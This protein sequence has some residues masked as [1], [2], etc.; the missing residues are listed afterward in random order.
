MSDE[1]VIRVRYYDGQYLRI[2][3][4]TDEQNYHIRMRRRHNIGG[5][6]WGVVR[7]LG[8]GLTDPGTDPKGGQGPFLDP[9]MAID[10]FG[11]EL[12]VVQ[13][14]PLDINQFDLWNVDVLDVWLNYSQS[15]SNPTAPGYGDCRSPSALPGLFNR[16]VEDPVLSYEPAGTNPDRRR[17]RVIAPGDNPFGP[18]RTPPDSPQVLWPVF[19][20]RFWRT[21]KPLLTSNQ[22]LY[23]VDIS[24][25]PY[26]GLVGESVVAPSGLA[27][28]QLGSVS[29]PELALDQ[30][31]AEKEAPQRQFAVYVATTSSAGAPK[32]A[33]ART[34]SGISGN[35][36][37]PDL[38]ASAP[39]LA[40][41]DG[42]NVSVLGHTMLFGDLTIDG[43]AAE[44]RSPEPLPEVQAVRFSS[45]DST[46]AATNKLIPRPWTI[47]KS[48]EPK[49]PDQSGSTTAPATPAPS[50]PAAAA[51][52]G[53]AVGGG[54]APLAG[55]P[56][57]GGGG[58][59]AGGGTTTT[60]AQPFLNELRVVIADDQGGTAKPATGQPPSN[61]FSV[62]FFSKES[63]KFQTV[64]SVSNR[65]V[66][67]NGDLVVK[68]KVTANRG[69]VD[70]P[71]T[72]AALSAVTSA[73]TAGVVGSGNSPGG[74]SGAPLEQLAIMLGDA[75]GR[76]ALSQF[77]SD[78][79]LHGPFLSLLLGTEPG[80]DALLR[81][82]VVDDPST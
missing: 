62:G 36:P 6:S 9:G 56:A 30:Q 2:Q 73:F 75:A 77:I 72:P 71:L 51:G 67:I 79:R 29:S 80:V 32:P 1:P 13:R 22:Y 59:A 12:T 38:A 37:S 27:L 47:Y 5:H 26:A 61:L 54:V 70:G 49:A 16:F 76:V 35:C 55:P 24:G 48:V 44:F 7:G 42:G 41:D 66:S 34:L 11:R 8:L 64:L 40:I 39:R 28:V 50:L 18:Q 19:V 57:G 4:F 15:E 21:A 45:G 65:G 74:L 82:F 68:G 43:G 52:A 14:Q 78:R 10:G 81:R 63:S 69:S 53:A 3:E 20:G 33:P 60:A 23:Q 58:A 17:S 25:R 31:A 46:P